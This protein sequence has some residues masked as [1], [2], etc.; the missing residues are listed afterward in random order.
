MYAFKFKFF[1][2]NIGF[3]NA[4]VSFLLRIWLKRPNRQIWQQLRLSSLPHRW[5]ECYSRLKVQMRHWRNKCDIEIRTSCCGIKEYWM[6]IKT[7]LMKFIR[8]MKTT[9]NWQLNLI[10]SEP[11]GLPQNELMTATPKY[12]C[13]D[14]TDCETSQGES[15]SSVQRDVCSHFGRA[16]WVYSGSNYHRNASAIPSA[17]LNQ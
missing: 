4:N 12:V 15:Y 8:E 16:F 9:L 6:R 7:D 5:N 10:S 2:T 14:H 3:G 13:H 11:P 17:A 1:E